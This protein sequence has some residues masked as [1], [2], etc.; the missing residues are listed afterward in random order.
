MPIEEVS[1][2]AKLWNLIDATVKW[3]PQSA[4]Q[5]KQELQILLDLLNNHRALFDEYQIE[6][7]GDLVNSIIILRGELE[8]LKFQDGFATEAR[9]LAQD[10][11]MKFQ[12]N[13][14]A[15]S[16]E[17]L[18]DPKAIQ[19][20]HTL[21]VSLNP[22]CA[23]FLSSYLGELRARVKIVLEAVRRRGVL[24]PP[25]LERLLTDS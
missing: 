9:G 23:S 15:L 2:T 12:S 8:K 10:A 3:E 22:F 6:I 17:Y 20:Q 24:I 19:Q 18:H 14:E 16:V 4:D 5:Q 25:S 21:L 11:C 13:V 1:V 7:V